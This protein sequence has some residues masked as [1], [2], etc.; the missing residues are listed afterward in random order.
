MGFGY[1]TSRRIEG[2]WETGTQTTKLMY[3]CL[4]T[5]WQKTEGG[6]RKVISLEVETAIRQL[7]NNMPWFYQDEIQK[8]LHEA[9]ILRYTDHSGY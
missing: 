1:P 8:F 7:L 3:L 9:S 4:I 2:E 5:G 6:L